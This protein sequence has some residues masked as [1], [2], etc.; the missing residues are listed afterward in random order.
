MPLP[1]TN[2][3]INQSGSV[4]HS[5]APRHPVVIATITTIWNLDVCSQI[6]DANARFR[7][8]N[9]SGESLGL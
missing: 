7:A 5:L 3:M 6:F 1:D 8:V 2:L 9:N 4:A